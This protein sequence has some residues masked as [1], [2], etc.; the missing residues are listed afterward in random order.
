LVEKTK[1]AAILDD[2]S[3]LEH[4]AQI[5]HDLGENRTQIQLLTGRIATYETSGRRGSGMPS[6]QEAEANY[7]NTGDDRDPPDFSVDVD[8]DAADVFCDCVSRFSQDHSDVP[9]ERMRAVFS[10]TPDYF[11]ESGSGIYPDHYTINRRFNEPSVVVAM[12]EL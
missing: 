4:Q 7:T 12:F 8:C 1:R 6:R 10:G 5:Y 2:G 11:F 3:L 9:T